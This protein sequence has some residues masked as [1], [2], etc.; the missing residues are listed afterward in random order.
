[1]D[2]GGT[3]KVIACCKLMLLVLVVVWEDEADAV[4]ANDAVR[5]VSMEATSGTPA[6]AVTEAVMVAVVSY[7]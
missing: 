6:V 2:S 7:C 5:V 1:M 4:T 3:V